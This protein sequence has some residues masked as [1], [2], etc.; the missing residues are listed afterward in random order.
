MATYSFTKNQYPNYVESYHNRIVYIK[1]VPTG[2]YL[3]GVNYISGLHKNIFS[4]AL[5]I[6]KY[7][8][9][10]SVLDSEQGDFVFWFRHIPNPNE[11]SYSMAPAYKAKIHHK[12]NEIK[13]FDF[14]S[15][16]NQ[17]AMLYSL[18]T[19]IET[20]NFS[21]RTVRCLREEKIFIIGQ[22]AIRPEDGI[23]RIKNL[24]KSSFDEIGRT[25]HERRLSFG[26]PEHENLVSA[27]VKIHAHTIG[28]DQLTTSDRTK[29]CLE[30]QNILNLGSLS[31]L[32]LEEVKGIKNFS[33]S[34]YEEVGK[35]LKDHGLEFADPTHQEM[36]TAKQNFTTPWDHP[37]GSSKFD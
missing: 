6:L 17:L 11:E 5:H 27:F 3:P 1:H 2:A 32:S 25:L 29:K 13:E 20:I 31:Q 34:S 37:W 33:E 14:K 26:M 10:Q 36:V 28:I 23:K 24:S 15:Y 35:I 7:Q 18:P 19:K 16:L 22:I 4:V 12:V 21:D 8:P 9:V 30:E